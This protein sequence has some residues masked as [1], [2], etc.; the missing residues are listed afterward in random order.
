MHP[1]LDL[2][3]RERI[4]RDISCLPTE[5]LLMVYHLVQT[6][7]APQEYNPSSIQNA[8]DRSRRIL[9]KSKNSFATEIV[10]A[11]SERI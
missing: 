11:R 9:S 1:T 10:E 7:V 3:V 5:R 6:D 4:I 8:L 2:S